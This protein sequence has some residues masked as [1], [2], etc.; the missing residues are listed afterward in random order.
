MSPQKIFA[1][2]ALLALM[3]LA[4]GVQAQ[5]LNLYG[6]IDL[7]F[8]SFQNS[9]AETADNPRVTKLR[10]EGHT[11]DVGS[12]AANQQ[13]TAAEAD[14]KRRD[15]LRAGAPARSCARSSDRRQCAC[16]K[17]GAR[18]K[19]RGKASPSLTGG[20]RRRAADARRGVAPG[21]DARPC[22]AQLRQ[23]AGPL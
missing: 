5:S 13:R 4:P 3:G 22:R 11:D 20:A 7:A 8:G 15:A 2:A 12:D 9:Y 21:R 19:R 23:G 10:V 14:T 6:V 1:P 17:C 18:L 16:A